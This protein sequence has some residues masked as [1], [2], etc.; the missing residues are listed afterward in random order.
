MNLKSIIKVIPVVNTT[1]II[2]YIILFFV[3]RQENSEEEIH[4]K[5]AFDNK[6]LSM[7]PYRIITSSVLHGGLEHLMGNVLSQ[8]ILGSALESILH[9]KIILVIIII[10]GI[11]GLLLCIYEDR[12]L[13]IGASGIVYGFAGFLIGYLMIYWSNYKIIV[14]IEKYI[15]SGIVVVSLVSVVVALP[16]DIIKWNVDDGIAHKSHVFAFF[17]GFVT[18]FM[19]NS[20]TYKHNGKVIQTQTPGEE[21]EIIII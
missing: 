2:F 11:K 3:V 16:F 1:Y 15:C 19:T 4:D 14:D 8:L 18:F 9:F 5:Y 21:M 13:I 12:M 6:K 10:S 20:L 7:E 17:I